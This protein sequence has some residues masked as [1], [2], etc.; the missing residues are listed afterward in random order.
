MMTIVPTPR[1]YRVRKYRSKYGECT[2]DVY[3]QTNVLVENI[4]WIVDGLYIADWHVCTWP[5]YSK[6]T[7]FGLSQEEC[8]QLNSGGG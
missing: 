7:Q 4:E 1:M 6:R 5:L 8:A 3:E 2:Y